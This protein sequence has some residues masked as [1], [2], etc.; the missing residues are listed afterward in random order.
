MARPKISEAEAFATLEG[1]AASG[2]RCPITGTGGLTSQLTGNLARAGKIRID[3]YPHNW[4]VVTIMTGPHAGKSTAPAPNKHWKPYLTIQ[5]DSP[6]KP[7]YTR[8]SP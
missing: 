2:A 6:P 4:R 3:V 5:K 8:V 7:Q 1:A